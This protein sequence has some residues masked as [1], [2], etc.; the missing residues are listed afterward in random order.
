MSALNSTFIQARK[1]FI[2]VEELHALMLEGA[3]VLD[4]RV[5]PNLSFGQSIADPG[6]TGTIPGSF[7]ARWLDF[8]I[9]VDKGHLKLVPELQ[10]MFRQRSVSNDRPVVIFGRWNESFGEEGRIF[11]QLHFLGHRKTYILYRG[12]FAWLESG[13]TTSASRTPGEFLA[14]PLPQ[15]LTHQGDLLETEGNLT[16][17]VDTRSPMEYNGGTPC[18]CPRGGHLPKAL[19]FNWLD[20]FEEDDTHHLK[21]SREILN[22][23]KEKLSVDE[24]SSIVVYCTRG[25]RSSF[26]YAVLFSLG[27][28]RISNYTG[29]FREWSFNLE[30]PIEV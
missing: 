8:L 15:S 7:E 6:F 29:S 2:S 4:A 25:I 17:L 16:T 28:N 9:D 24:D 20:V 26:M 1:V 21:L 5:E 14:D 12:V 10:T 3:T 19:P 18:G 22:L 13:F 27:F 30:L 11:W 23:L